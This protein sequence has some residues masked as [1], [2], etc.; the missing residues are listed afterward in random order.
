MASFSGSAADMLKQYGKAVP[1]TQPLTGLEESQ[2]AKKKMDGETEV[3]TDDGCTEDHTHGHSHG[4]GEANGGAQE[5]TR[6]SISVED[7]ELG[8]GC[9]LIP[10][11]DHYDRHW[12]RAE[13]PMTLGRDPLP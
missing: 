8:C 2:A 13:H 1:E 9:S 7:V 3:C 5:A 6:F 4:H 11:A 12:Q 10:T